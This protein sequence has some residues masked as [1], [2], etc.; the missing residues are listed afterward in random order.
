MPRLGALACG[1][2]DP[3]M[4]TLR[5]RVRPDA[6]PARRPPRRSSLL[7]GGALA[8]L[9][10]A[11]A[12]PTGLGARLARAV[13]GSADLDGVFD[14]P[15]PS[16]EA[17]DRPAIRHG[18]DDWDRVLLDPLFRLEP[19]DVPPDL[20][21][22]G[23]A[24]LDGSGSVRLLVVDDLRAMGRAARRSGVHLVVRSA[25]RDAED[26][27]RTVESLERAYGRAWAERSAAQPG[28]SE[29]QLG[30][31]LDLDGGDSWLAAHAWEWGFVVSYPPDRSPAYT[32]YRPEPWHVRYLGRARARAVHDSG[33][34]L[35]EW[36][37][38][39]GGDPG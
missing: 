21:P 14:G 23:E 18:P 22:V 13:A 31:A 33:L 2:D 35:R 38:A 9:V 34:S 29:H 19:D 6:A 8:T 10:I 27:R 4:P 1:S 37:W 5:S 12:W 24:G 32:C 39:H 36:L 20:V 3:V 30:T 26:Q 25:F 11:L 28:H 16:C 15:L 17:G 7:V